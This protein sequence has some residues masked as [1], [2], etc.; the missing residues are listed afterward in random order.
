MQIDRE[1]LV[2]FSDASLHVWEE[3]EARVDSDWGRDFKR[4]VFKRMVQQL[5]RM[6]FNL[7]L[8][9]HIFTGNDSR[10]GEKNGLRLDLRLCGRHIEL[11]FFQ[12]VNAPERPDH[13][14]RYQHDKEQQMP[15]LMR[16]RMERTRRRLRAYLCNVFAGYKFQSKRNDGRSS[17]RGPSDL[18][19]MEWI[20]G[21]WESSCHYKGDWEH[22]L[23][24]DEYTRNHNR[25]TASGTQLN[26]GDRVYFFDHKARVQTGTAYYNINN[27]WWVLTGKYDVRNEASFNLYTS[28]PDNFR[29]KRNERLRRSRLESELA[30]AIKAMDFQRAETLKSLLWTESD[31]LY[32]VWH[33]DHE[34]YHCT[35]WSGYTTD[36]IE[37]GKFTK[38]EITRM[39]KATDKAILFNRAA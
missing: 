19:G 14:G 23:A 28:L 13:G 15:Y 6:G 24:T 35:N 3:P 12:N 39:N 18:T 34:A 16:I 25:K 30:K 10:Y 5:N 11:N 32:L 27:M 31:E 17:K 7:R 38:D 21:C 20:K 2:V 26:Q 9:T 8:C 4:F 36:A 37:A 1:G 33:K 29:D 22:E